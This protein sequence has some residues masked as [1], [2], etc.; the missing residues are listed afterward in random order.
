V[1]GLNANPATGGARDPLSFWDFFDVPTTSARDGAIS[2]QDVVGVLRR[3]GSRRTDGEPEEEV[4]LTEAQ[5]A[6]PAAPAYHAAYDRTP[7]APFTGPPDGAI[8]V[9]D[10]ALVIA[11][12]GHT[13]LQKL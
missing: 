6:P 13:C 1:A 5:S 3:F 8:S 12:F 9:Q 7:R 11:Q 10:V 2:L 4:A